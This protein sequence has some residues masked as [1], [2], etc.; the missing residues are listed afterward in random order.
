MQYW[1]SLENLSAIEVS[2][3][4][5]ETFLANQFAADVV[6]IAP[7]SALR[8][9]WC[10]PKGRILFAPLVYRQAEHFVCLVDT[11]LTAAFCQRLQM[12][13]LRADVSVR[14]IED[15]R[16]VGARF[17]P[18]VDLHKWLAESSISD[19]T[20]LNLSLGDMAT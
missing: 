2:G 7:G 20:L 17:S 16:C 3:T 5:A 4:E 19:A 13:I 1:T 10:N 12:F 15:A 14:T 11:E 18:D 9:A 6:G 8:S